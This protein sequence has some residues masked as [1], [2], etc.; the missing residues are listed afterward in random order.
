M[1]AGLRDSSI[2]RVRGVSSAGLLSADDTGRG[3][4]SLGQGGSLSSY[5]QVIAGSSAAVDVYVF[6]ILCHSAVD[7]RLPRLPN[8][9][10]SD[11]DRRGLGSAPGH[12]FSDAMRRH[13]RVDRRQ[14]LNPDVGPIQRSACAIFVAMLEISRTMS[15]LTET[16]TCGLVGLVGMRTVISAPRTGPSSP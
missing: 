16:T 12:W 6:H 10:V 5:G 1:G 3:L 11:G 14:G 13:S 4:T 9:G 8:H 2:M 15:C 7:Q